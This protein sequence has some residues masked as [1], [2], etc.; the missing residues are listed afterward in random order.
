MYRSNKITFRFF[1]LLTILCVALCLVVFLSG[2]A[3]RDVTGRGITGRGVTDRG[4]ADHGVAHPNITAHDFYSNHSE[5]VSDDSEPVSKHSK[6]VSKHSKSSFGLTPKSR[7]SH[8]IPSDQS[9]EKSVPLAKELSPTLTTQPPPTFAKELSPSSAVQTVPPASPSSSKSEP[10]TQPAP[11]SQC[12]PATQLEPASKTESSLSQKK[13]SRSGGSGGFFS[14]I[15]GSDDYT[16]F[17]KGKDLYQRQEYEKAA[18][19][20]LEIKDRHPYGNF[21]ELADDHLKKTEE[22]IKIEEATKKK[23]Q[24]LSEDQP[25]SRYQPLPEDQS[26]LPEK[27][28]STGKPVKPQKEG[29]GLEKA[30]GNLPNP[31]NLPDSGKLTDSGKSTNSGNLPNTGKLTSSEKLLS[32]EFYDTDVREIIRNIATETGINLITDDTIQG[33]ISVKYKDM[34]IENVLKII[35]SAGGYTFRKM[36]GYYLIGTADP[37]SPLFNYLSR[38]EYVKPKFLKA[39]ELV[40]LISPAFVSAI[41][42]NE[43]RNMLTITASP[44]IIERI[45][46]DI[47]KV[48]KVPKQVKLEAIIVDLTSDAKKNLGIDWEG[49]SGKFSGS[50]ENLDLTFGYTQNLTQNLTQMITAKIHELV[51][52]GQATLRATPHVT[53]MDGEEATI[54][55][56]LEQ[57]I[58]ITTGPVTYAYTNIQTI[59]AGITLNIIPYVSDDNTILVK[60]KPAEVSDF[61]ETASNGLPLINKRSVNTTVVVKD[62]ETIAIGG[63]LKKREINKIS[64]V[65]ILGYIP[66]LNLFFSKKEKVTEDSEVLILITPQIVDTSLL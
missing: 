7:F 32:N 50:M 60:I 42:V 26:L 15:W 58:S 25:L 35:L 49:Q 65:P 17:K 43:E 39:K 19:K 4:V 46:E 38:T 40:K 18:Q 66:I 14:W 51:Q 23:D 10:A 53:T 55:I 52:N 5:P 11:A 1:S 27:E 13:N 2:C 30:S 56:G 6:S 9:K 37:R 31:G 34:A 47:K 45:V 22:A 48:D 36:E 57:Y 61:V 20:F 28:P 59:K 21:A 44:E 3:H 41:Q 63:F 16:T 12:A 33:I 24:H 64:R 54:N 29:K 62:R 8:S